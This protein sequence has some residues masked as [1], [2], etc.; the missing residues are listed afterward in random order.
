[1]V[2]LKT[3]LKALFA[4]EFGLRPNA[5]Q[6]AVRQAFIGSREREN[7]RRKPGI[8]HQPRPH[9]P[10]LGVVADAGFVSLIECESRWQSFELPFLGLTPK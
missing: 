8:M 3:P 5:A 6:G 2:R 10:G 1:M 9:F 4:L 7:Y